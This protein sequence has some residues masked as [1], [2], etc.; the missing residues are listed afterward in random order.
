MSKLDP[1]MVTL[2]DHLDRDKL[3]VQSPVSNSN[4]WYTES[5]DGAREKAS[6]LMKATYL[7]I[8]KDTKNNNKFKGALTTQVT[9]ALGI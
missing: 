8:C 4:S 6:K 7:A 1:L 3:P 2:V 9:Q 5:Y